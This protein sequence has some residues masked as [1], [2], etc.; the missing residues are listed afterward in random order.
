MYSNQHRAI[1]FSFGGG[2][3]GFSFFTI[4]GQSLS[5]RFSIM[6]V[7]ALG[8]LTRYENGVERTLTQDE[9]QRYI[10]EL[11]EVELLNIPL[12]CRRGH[13]TFL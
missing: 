2:A 7:P 4:S 8:E 6:N 11:V 12:T 9:F 13:P 3:A 1:A 10:D 5:F